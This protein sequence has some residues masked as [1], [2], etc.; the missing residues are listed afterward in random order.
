MSE[1]A[2]ASMG[3]VHEYARYI[4][5]D[6]MREPHLLW[7][8]EEALEASLPEGWSE[9]F[10]AEDEPYYHNHATSEVC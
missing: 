6:P 1:G 3:E 10:D 9:H 4:G 8:A 5:M 2:A 7:I